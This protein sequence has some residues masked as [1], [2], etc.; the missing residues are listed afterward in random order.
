M[1][2]ACKC[3]LSTTSNQ[4]FCQAFNELERKAIFDKFWQHLTWS[5]KKVYIRGLVDAAT[6]KSHRTGNKIDPCLF[7]FLL[8]GFFLDIQGK[9]RQVAYRFYQPFVF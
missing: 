6:P 5:E 2:P 3:K 7:L 1:G 4:F 9:Q 8:T